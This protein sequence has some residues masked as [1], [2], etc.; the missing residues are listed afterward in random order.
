MAEGLDGH[1]VDP[2]GREVTWHRVY[3]VKAHTSL[4]HDL[5][6]ALK[7]LQLAPPLCGPGDCFQLTPHVLVCKLAPDS[8]GQG[9][10]EEE[11]DGFIGGR[12][13]KQENLQV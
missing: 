11:A 4:R 1:L 6:L 3:W 2:A 5:Q 10:T 7:S 13:Y 9:E 12:V 8:E